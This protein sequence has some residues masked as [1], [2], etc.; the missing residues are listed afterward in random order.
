[1]LS[2]VRSRYASWAARSPLPFSSSRF[3]L[4]SLPRGTLPLLVAA[5]ALCGCPLSGRVP[6]ARVTLAPDGHGTHRIVALPAASA[7]TPA[8]A[9]A[10]A[11]RI[12]DVAA[13]GAGD[14]EVGYGA[15]ESLARSELELAGYVLVDSESLNGT[16]RDRTESS[17]RTETFDRRGG[18]SRESHEITRGSDGAFST[19]TKEV[20]EQVLDTLAVDTL[21]ETHVSV[22]PLRMPHRGDPTMEQAV[23]IELTL[24]SRR[25]A[26]AVIRSVCAADAGAYASSAQ[27]LERAARCAVDGMLAG[28]D[29]PAP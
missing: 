13:L 14:L 5:S 26:K 23:S 20:Q 21:F 25:S 29:R 22:G 3:A 15:V 11:P 7:V 2:E 27:A 8:A 17:S 16:T 28:L 19:A 10:A 24:T 1:M 6:E 9:N 4:L 12:A 18:S